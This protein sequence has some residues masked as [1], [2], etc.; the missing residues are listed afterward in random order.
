MIGIYEDFAL[1]WDDYPIID[2]LN[3]QIYS[4]DIPPAYVCS[5]CNEINRYT[6]LI[7]RDITV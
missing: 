4:N 1:E 2:N 6:Y 5:I 7:N 3:Y